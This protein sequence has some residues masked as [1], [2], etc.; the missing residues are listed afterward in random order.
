MRLAITLYQEFLFETDGEG[1]RNQKLVGNAHNKGLW[2]VQ[3][4]KT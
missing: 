2:V 3:P 1:Y 4:N